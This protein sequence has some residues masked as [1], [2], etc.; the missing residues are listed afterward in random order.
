MSRSTGTETAA[1][2]VAFSVA[3]FTV[4]TTSPIALRFFSTR[5]AHE[6]HVIP[7]I[8]SS[9]SLNDDDTSPVTAAD[10][11]PPPPFR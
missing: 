2:T 3:K 1:M 7:R 6:A 5:A 9:T 11:M 4:A 8:E 10:D